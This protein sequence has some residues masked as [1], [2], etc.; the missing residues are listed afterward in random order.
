MKSKKKGANIYIEVFLFYYK[1]EYYAEFF[2]N[3]Y[4]R[5]RKKFL[6]LIKVLV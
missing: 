5:P 3:Y 2:Y 6:V 4:A 1:A